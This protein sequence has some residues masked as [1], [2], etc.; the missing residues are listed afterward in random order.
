VRRSTAE[1]PSPPRAC[2][3]VGSNVLTGSVPSSL[4]ALTKLAVLE[5][6]KNK[7]EGTLSALAPLVSAEALRYV[8]LGDNR[9]TGSIPE[10]LLSSKYLQVLALFRNQLTGPLD[11]SNASGLEVFAAFGNKLSGSIVLPG[12]LCSLWILLIHVNFFSC[13]VISSGDCPLWNATRQ[14]RQEADSE[15]C[16]FTKSPAECAK[17][18]AAPG[19]RLQ[20]CPAAGLVDSIAGPKWDATNTTSYL[21]NGTAWQTWRLPF[22]AFLLGGLA[23]FTAVATTGVV[24]LSDCSPAQPS[25]CVNLLPAAPTVQHGLPAVRTRLWRFVRFEPLRGVGVVQLWCARRLAWLAIPSLATV[26]LGNTFVSAHLYTCGDWLTKYLTIAYI[27]DPAAEWALAVAACAFSYA[28]AR[29]VLQFQQMLQA[30]YPSPQQPPPARSSAAI[31]R[32]YA[33]WA[34][35]CALYSTVPFA[36]A[37]STS[38]PAE[39]LGTYGAW[40]LPLISQT[41]SLVLS[42]VTSVA[43]PA[44]CRRL[45][46]G[47]FGANGHPLLTSR[48]MQLARLLVSI[49][50]PVLAIILVHE[51]CLGGWKLLWHRCTDPVSYD[52]YFHVQIKLGRDNYGNMKLDDALVPLDV[53]G[54]RYRPGRCSRAVVEDL[55]RLLLSKLAYAAFLLPAVALVLHTPVWRRTKEAVIRCF[56]PTYMAAYAVDSEFTA[57]LM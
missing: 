7:L 12:A 28:A 47:I 25:L 8:L 48:L 14:A 46:H 30:E 31:S 17:G 40:I 45:S 20:A 19:N 21:W 29:F 49:L 2:S 44:H 53:C 55:G 26:T 38:L 3:S 4:S 56:K 36:Y 54:L 41:T 1:R 6:G 35:V 32:M 39:S 42:I 5:M 51:D 11:L 52:S 10:A 50:A 9:F 33:E 16:N 57:I 15:F 34:V 13:T 27:D 24:L 43:I 23:M 18:L 37:F 22:I